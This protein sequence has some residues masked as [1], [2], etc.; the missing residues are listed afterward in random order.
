[1]RILRAIDNHSIIVFI[2]RY[3]E[4]PVGKTHLPLFEEV[5]FFFCNVLKGFLVDGMEIISEK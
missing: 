2:F 5:N 3:L 4:I 1:M